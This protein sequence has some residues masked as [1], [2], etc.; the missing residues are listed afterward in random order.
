MYRCMNLDLKTPVGRVTLCFP[1]FNLELDPDQ[2]SFARFTTSIASSTRLIFGFKPL[3]SCLFVVFNSHF[4]PGLS[5]RKIVNYLMIRM[6][7]R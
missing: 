5:F 1:L 4:S 7:R 6:V 3:Y 2:S